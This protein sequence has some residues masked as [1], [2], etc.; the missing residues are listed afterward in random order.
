MGVFTEIMSILADIREIFWPLLEPENKPTLKR[1]KR[2][3][4]LSGVSLTKE[5]DLDIAYDLALKYYETEE[6]RKSSV[7]AKS[8]VFIACIGF[9]ITIILNLGKDIVFAS[10]KS[11]AMSLVFVFLI[12]L[13]TVYLC[14]TVWFAIQALQRRSYHKLAPA[15]FSLERS[16]GYKKHL[17]ATLINY[18]DKNSVQNNAKVEHMTMAQEYFKRAIVSMGL[19]AILLL[20]IA[21]LK[22]LNAGGLCK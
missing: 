15:D 14:R 8:T 6:A 10:E 3:D 12:T 2:I 20:F 17:I 19:Y 5:T 7:E 21:V 22:A 16:S 18:T 4:S 13:I 1:T 9:G 11:N